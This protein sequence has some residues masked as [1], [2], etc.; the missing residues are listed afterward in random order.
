MAFRA[1]TEGLHDDEKKSS[2][3]TDNLEIL[4]RRIQ[5]KLLHETKQSGDEL[6]EQLRNM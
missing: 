5:K 3:T 1:F 4:L 6:L 2:V